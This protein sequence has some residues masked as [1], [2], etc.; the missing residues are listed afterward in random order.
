MR[1]AAVMLSLL[2]LVVDGGEIADLDLVGEHRAGREH[3][4][5]RHGDAGIV[6]GHHLQGRIVALLRR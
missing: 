6:L 2:Q 4:H 5:A 1:I 3:L